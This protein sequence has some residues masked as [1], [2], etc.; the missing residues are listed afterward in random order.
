[1]LN[2]DQGFPRNN[3][4]GR[5][6][7]AGENITVNLPNS[8]EAI[9]R[10]EYAVVRSLIRVLEGGVEGKR[11]VDKVIDKCAS[12]QVSVLSFYLMGFHL[13]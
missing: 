12:M 3:S 10:G 2:K 4:F 13:G 7:K 9:R 5:I 8:E 1:M 11:Q 6:F